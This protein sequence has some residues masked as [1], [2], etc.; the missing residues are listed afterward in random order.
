M[1]QVCW[2]VHTPAG[3]DR[4]RAAPSLTHGRARAHALTQ[5]KAAVRRPHRARP[6]HLCVCDVEVPAPGQQERRLLV[7]KH[8]LADIDEA[9]ER[10]TLLKLLRAVLGLVALRGH[11]T[12][13]AADWH[14]H[15]ALCV[16]V[17][18]CACARACVC[19]CVYLHACVCAC[20]RA[21]SCVYV[22]VH[23][24]AYVCARVYPR[25]DARVHW[26]VHKYLAQKNSGPHSQV[27]LLT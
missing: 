5:S 11:M 17:R 15:E 18:V 20:M 22:C 3:A 19:A 13:S 4:P 21:C 8:Q 14:G 12:S 25:T 10:F 23:V 24:Y 7:A 2:D 26:V 16:C 1:Q 27:P 9:L 6:A